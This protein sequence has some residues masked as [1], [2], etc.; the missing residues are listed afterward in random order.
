MST[1]TLIKTIII[2]AAGGDPA[3]GLLRSL[4]VGWDGH[5]AKLRDVPNGP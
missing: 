1:S 5:L 3:F 2:D 4:D